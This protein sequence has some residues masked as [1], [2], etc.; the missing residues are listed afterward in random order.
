MS[1]R[2]RRADLDRAAVF[3]AILGD[4]GQDAPSV[5]DAGSVAIADIVY[6]ERQPR[7]FIE[8]FALAALT[9]SIRERGVLEPVLVRR[10]GRSYELVAGERRTR[11]ARE[12][13]LSHVPAIVLELDDREALEISIM[14]NLQREDLNAVEE[15]EAVLQLLELSLESD[16]G[17]AL[18]LLNELVQESRG[19]APQ[20]RFT[21][22]Q[23][24]VASELFERLGRFT[25]ASFVANRV[26]ILGFP[27][28]LLDTVRDGRLSFTKA[29]ALARIDDPA[30][31][32][33][34]LEEAIRDE[35]SLSQIRRRLT[36]LRADH[37]VERSIDDEV[38][39]R[40]HSARRLLQR[41]ALA[42][43]SHDRLKRVGG[44][45]DEL[46]ELLEGR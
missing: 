22:L 11:A 46:L 1:A 17:G 15:T 32:R 38:L 6:N 18:A 23:K 26:P 5:A 16:R 14:E 36:E 42:R 7:Q 12:A 30:D 13:G 10:V 37:R 25:P 3:E 33:R 28:E 29:Q 31:R 27:S 9:A 24:A 39:D 20:T 34:L 2:R 44:L 41:R 43:L 40:M 35:L 4:L 21:A 45:L 19:R 8:P